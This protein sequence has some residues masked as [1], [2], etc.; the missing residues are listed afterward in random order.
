MVLV[1]GV[2][3]V[4]AL[5]AFLAIGKWKSPFNRRD[6]P[7]R[8]GINIQQ[9]ANG[10]T[11]AE[12]R[13]GHALFK[14][15]ASKVEQLKDNRFRLH[16]VKIEMYGANNSGMD[17]I[18]GS[19]FEYDQQTGIAEAA[20]P[21]EITLVRPGGPAV[22]SR[23]QGD[24]PTV[25]QAGQPVGIGEIHVKTSGLTF[26]QNS[27]VAS[28][29]QKVE[30]E[31]AQGSG[32][33]IGASYDSQN[34]RLVLDRAVE[35]NT[36]RGE[37]PLNLRAQH[38]EFEQ[39]DQICRLKAA[40]ARYRG[41]EAALE[42][43]TIRFRQDGS[44]ERLDA[45]NGLVLTT[46]TGGRLSAPTGSL[47][48]DAKSNP[49]HGHL[50]GGVIIDSDNDGRRLHGTSPTV[51]LA[52]AAPG[53]LSHA[54]LERGVHFTS[55][56]QTTSAAGSSQLHRTWASPMAD[57]EF[58]NPGKGQAE[59]KSIHGTGGVVATSDSQRNG[60]VAPSRM[61]ADDVTGI[62]GA[63]SALTALTGVGHASMVETTQT[64]TRQST[65]GD[66]LEAHFAPGV[67]NPDT[68]HQAK[69]QS[70]PEGAMQVESATVEGNVVLVQQPAAKPDSPSPAFRATAT[71]AVYEG[72]GE[73]V[74]LTG[75]P[76]VEGGGLQLAA[77]K[78]DF[79]Q[80]SGDAFAHGDVKATWFGNGDGQ[81][82][83][84][85]HATASRIPGLGAQGPAHVIASEAQL[86][87]STG[88]AI[89][90]GQARLW[91]EGNSV[92]APVIVLDRTKQTLV[93]RTTNSAEPVRVVLVSAVGVGKGKANQPGT[94]SV[95]RVRGGDLKY[96]DAERKA[97][98]QGGAAGSVVAETADATTRSSDMELIL[99]PSG[100]RAAGQGT[101]AQVDRMT[102]R[103]RVLIDSL[104]R[105]GTG[106]QLVFTGES[107][108]YVLTGTAATPP[109]LSDPTRGTVTG[110]ALIFNSRDDS[111][112][113]E[114][115]GRT[116]MTETTAPKRP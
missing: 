17:R 74:H 55:D 66:R 70:T 49:Q 79:S 90:R 51:D 22:A 83:Q 47:L 112:R 29:A 50:E 4:V 21:V 9:E 65:S 94:P 78:I 34:G 25:P 61:A 40:A 73:L 11:H 84:A 99:L 100:N 18:E 72:N 2:L 88:D 103:G 3:L 97:V 16:V 85:A 45:S 106:E 92:A 98:M 60:V 71:R 57:L 68:K 53:V 69:D 13:A 37:D 113:V 32:S 5:G 10:F 23:A 19:E 39:G 30:F 76:R 109:R 35:L 64:G 77:E 54:H 7:K 108:D 80:A 36:L 86:H 81:P 27:G 31:L 62:F 15:T 58:G 26:D 46:V 42:E 38:G 91:Q 116:T 75:S 89:F 14:I 8:L 48:F 104:G 44:A 59:L 56:E 107:G 52:F 24:K 12:F 43:A 33:A 1:A 115:G 63:N 96:S 28:T 114:G 41:G 82:K 93:A 67:Q 101:A 102:A 95:I 20:G 105:R 87:L 110:D 111:V 6:L